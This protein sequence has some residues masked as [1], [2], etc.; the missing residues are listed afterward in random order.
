MDKY[1]FK[2]EDLQ[3]LTPLNKRD[4]GQ[5]AINAIIQEKYNP[6]PLVQRS[7]PFKVEDKVIHI[8]NNYELG[9]MNGEVGK[10]TWIATER[11]EEAARNAMGGQHILPTEEKQGAVLTVDYG[12]KV[13][14]YAR[15]ELADLKL[16]YAITIH[17]SQG[18]EFPA[19]IILVP[20]LW[21]GFELRQLVYTGITR[22]RQYCLVLTPYGAIEKYIKNEMRLHRNTMVAE[23]L[24]ASK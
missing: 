3:I 13:V 10:V 20:H 22:A 17:K 23:R 6:G 7:I 4:F 11:D 16:A 2:L 14:H 18:S 15:E 21:P 19:V 12:D 9:V 1:K 24:Q 5:K 8:M